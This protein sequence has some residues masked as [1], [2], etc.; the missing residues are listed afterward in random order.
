MRKKFIFLI[1]IGSYLTFILFAPFVCAISSEI[2]FIV[3][4]KEIEE[5]I[6][7]S[8]S[9]EIFINVNYKLKIGTIQK[10]FYFHTRIG[11]VL[12][13][14]FFK[15]YFFKYLVRQ[16]PK[17]NLTLSVDKPD[18]CEAELNKYA[19]E[20][21]Y[22]QGLVDEEVIL[23]INVNDNAPALQK[24]EIKIIANDEGVHNIDETSN[25]TNISF[26]AAYI[27]NILV[28]AELEHTI[29]P[30]KKTIVPI[31][32]TNN[33]NG[34]GIVSIQQI[35]QEQWNITFEQ[36]DIK[37]G[38]GEEKQIMMSVKPP[39][40]FD[41]VTINL[42]FV[43]LSTVEDVNHSYRQGNNVDLGITFLNDGSLKDEDELDI[44]TIL[45]IAIVVIIALIIVAFILKKKE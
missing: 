30:L 5:P 44:T 35:D 34:E 23:T 12:M 9:E 26:M 27:S 3:N 42:T 29:P 24:N 18:W 32:I 20:F 15:G 7:L 36:E 11:R 17:A 33:G 38:V 6:E 41:N 10:L 31:N 39:K 45:I 25:S 37:I 19:V 28:E 43:P 16:L 21:N 1:V 40:D 22:E 8:K 13:F 2:S 14:G 4:K